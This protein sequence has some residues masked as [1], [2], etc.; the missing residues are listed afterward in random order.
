MIIDF[1]LIFRQ[2]KKYTPLAQL[3]DPPTGGLLSRFIV[4]YYK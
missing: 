4:L 1:S 2:Y 3:V